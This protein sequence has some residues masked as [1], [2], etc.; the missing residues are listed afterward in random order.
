MYPSA[1]LMDWQLAGAPDTVACDVTDTSIHFLL[2]S[3]RPMLDSAFV[4]Y[5]RHL[6][7]IYIYQGVPQPHDLGSID[8]SDGHIRK[9]RLQTDQP[10][11]KVMCLVIV[12]QSS[13]LEPTPLFSNPVL[14]AYYI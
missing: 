11:S 12:G 9:L 5:M 3:T 8:I 7:N 2:Q 1:V 13:I 10:N 4:V 14:H 6:L